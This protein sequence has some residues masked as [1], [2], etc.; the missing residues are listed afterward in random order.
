LKADI[1]TTSEYGP[2]DGIKCVNK[3]CGFT[4]K[5][6]SATL[7]AGRTVEWLV[8][9]FVRSFG[10]LVRSLVGWLAGWFVRLTLKGSL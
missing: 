10:W 8:G 6:T 3:L 4:A 5:N 7:M 1:V 9:W 2:Q